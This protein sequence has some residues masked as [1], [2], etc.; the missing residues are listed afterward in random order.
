MAKF[1]ADVIV[2]TQEEWRQVGGGEGWR[3][4]L[5]ELAFDDT[6]S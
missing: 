6:S 4:H 2:I 5:S 1:I 3:I